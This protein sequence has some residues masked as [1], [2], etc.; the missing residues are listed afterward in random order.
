MNVIGGYLFYLLAAIKKIPNM[1]TIIYRGIP[2]SFKSKIESDYV[3]QRPIHWSGFSSGTTDLSVVQTF[4]KVKGI[5]FEIS[6]FTGKAIQSYS[7]LPEEN[8]VL[9]SPNMEFKVTQALCQRSDGFWYLKLQEES[10]HVY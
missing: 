7:I 4:A 10:L 3:L 6:V 9:L 8:E 1:K 2:I 5:I